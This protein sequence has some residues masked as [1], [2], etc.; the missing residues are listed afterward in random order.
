MA[1]LIAYNLV[2]MQKILLDESDINIL[3][4]KS[5]RWFW[6]GL[7]VLSVPLIGCSYSLMDALTSKYEDRFYLIASIVGLM[8]SSVLLLPLVLKVHPKF[9]RKKYRD[10]YK[11][12]EELDIKETRSSR[13]GRMDPTE[14]DSLSNSAYTL[15]YMRLS[16]GKEYPIEYKD[17]IDI[18]EGKCKQARLETAEKNGKLI[19]C[20][21]I[22]SESKFDHP[23]M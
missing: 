16:N 17:Y 11:I 19:S 6:F 14:G 2:K 20:R 23:Y 4:K 10:G 9:V 1:F 12:I 21:L 22:R 13:H 5:R 15:Y 3:V 8:L 18:G 7:I